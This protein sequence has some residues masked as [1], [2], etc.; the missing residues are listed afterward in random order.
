M[1][2]LTALLAPRLATASP[3]AEPMT[4]LTLTGSLAGGA[5]L[6]LSSG[7][8]GLLEAELTAGYELESIGL[9]PELGAALG[10]SPDSHVAVRPGLRW[11]VPE[12]PLQLR[13]AFD[14]SNA[15]DRSRWRWLL[16]GL[17]GEIRLTSVFGLY[18]EL[19]TGFPIGD[20]T[21][22]PLLFRAG[23]SFRL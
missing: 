19:D 13:A 6:G 3:V 1:V 4:G 8:A 15:R 11:N 23:A 22:L 14:W 9:R 5:E 12:T 2:V 16:L 18:G 21:G 17:A 20:R 10:L 7:K